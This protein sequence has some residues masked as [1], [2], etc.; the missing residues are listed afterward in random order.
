MSMIKTARRKVSIDRFSEILNLN[1]RGISLSVRNT[2]FLIITYVYVRQILMVGCEGL[3]TVPMF[4]M[5]FLLY[6]LVSTGIPRRF[7]P[8]PWS[9]AVLPGLR[10]GTGSWRP[11]FS[12]VRDDGPQGRAG[13]WP[14]Q[15]SDARVSPSTCL[16]VSHETL[17]PWR[18]RL[19]RRC[20]CAGSIVCAGK[21][22]LVPR[23][24]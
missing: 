16:I 9:P 20:L 3:W 8:I 5:S 14:L 19:Q 23:L 6:S 12:G 4:Y 24:L 21:R 7:Y 18:I 15:G 10:H 13:R 17:S 22:G 2:G 11:V 1:S